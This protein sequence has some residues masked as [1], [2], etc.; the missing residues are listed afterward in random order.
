MSAVE[1]ADRLRRAVDH[2]QQDDGIVDDLAPIRREL[3]PEHGPEDMIE[4]S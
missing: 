3:D 4:N 1:N 2:Q